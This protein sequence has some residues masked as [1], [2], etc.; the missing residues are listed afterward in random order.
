[1]YVI[2]PRKLTTSTT[3]TTQIVT[4]M[5]KI[6]SLLRAA[7]QPFFR[8]FAPSSFNAS[9]STLQKVKFDENVAK[10]SKSTEQKPS[11][12][13][14]TSRL[15]LTPNNN[16]MHAMLL[17][18]VINEQQKVNDLITS[19]QALQINKVQKDGDTLPVEGGYQALNRSARHPKRANRGKRPVCR[20]GR[21]AK[22][23]RWGNHRR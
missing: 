1:M 6:P 19:I 2:N 16:T 22:K 14:T 11:E 21:R 8:S 23:R 13:L 15:R 10:N 7:T 4:T 12:I 9:Y 5:M 18:Q 3:S 20:H 17:Q